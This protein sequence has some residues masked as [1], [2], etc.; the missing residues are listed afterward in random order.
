MQVLARLNC[1][2]RLT[3]WVLRV[4]HDAHA[5]EWSEILFIETKVLNNIALWILEQFNASASRWEETSDDYYDRNMLVSMSRCLVKVS[6]CR[7][8]VCMWWVPAAAHK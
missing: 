7:V 6:R 4:L 5:S 8:S 1:R 2:C 3:S